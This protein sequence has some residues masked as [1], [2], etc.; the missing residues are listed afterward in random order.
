VGAATAYLIPWSLLPDAIDADP[1]KPAG[2][3]TAWMVFGQ[4]LIIGL[5]MSVFGSLLS[6]TGYIS[7]K[8]GNCSGA[9]SFIE[10]PDSALLAI[11]LC[12][13]LIPAILVLLGLVVMR[14]WPDRGAHLQKAAG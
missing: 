14:G 6:L 3:Y 11:R 4:K 13:G 12:M 2:L 1:S 7:A 5:T 9:L 8:G 10:Q